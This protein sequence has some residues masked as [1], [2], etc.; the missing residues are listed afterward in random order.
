MADRHRG[1]PADPV[2]HEHGQH[3]GKGGTPV[4]P[5][6]VGVL[7]AERVEHAD[8][9]GDQGAHPVCLDRLGLGGVAEAAQVRRDHPVAGIGQSGDLVPPE[10]PG[11]GEAVQQQHRRPAA[12][13]G[14]VEIQPVDP[15]G[16]LGH[17]R[18]QSAT[19]LSR[20]S[21]RSTRCRRFWS[22]R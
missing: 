9:V 12:R 13:L 14:Q 4:V 2:G 3:P 22:R 15:E 10:P 16:L 19:S 18:H 8:D 7:D 5:G 17:H 20:P 21:R 1:Q 6:D 11:I